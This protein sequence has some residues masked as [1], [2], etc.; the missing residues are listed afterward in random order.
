[1]FYRCRIYKVIPE[2]V[3]IFN[4]FFR[5]YLLP[6]QLKHGARL[7]GRWQTI[8]GSHEI[9][10]VWEYDSEAH[11]QQVERAVR[12]D[13]NSKAARQ[14]RKEIEPLFVE[15]TEKFMVATV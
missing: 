4:E 2:K 13:P 3:E 5:T 6:T 10:A 7:V 15:R 11:Y 9:I 8:D 14:K 1:M 12:D